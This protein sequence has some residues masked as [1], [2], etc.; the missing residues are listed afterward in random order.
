[1][2][3]QVPLCH[4]GYALVDHGDAERV[5]C[6]KW[7]VNRHGYVMT[8]WYFKETQ[9]TSSRSLH[10]LLV[11]APQDK[12]I[13]HINGD[14]LDNRRANLR[15]VTAQINQANRRKH[16]PR[17]TS[18]VRGVIRYRGRWRAQI[19]VDGRCLQLGAYDTIE[20]A[21]EIRRAAERAWWGE[22]CP[23]PDMEV[24]AA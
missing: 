16:D 4:G 1:M 2:T 5:M 13:D 8:S 19:M 12:H 15:V 23:I 3:V 10:R 18:G 7:R 14:K 24:Q 6:R 20:D 21:A 9:K 17:N 11:D 22:Q